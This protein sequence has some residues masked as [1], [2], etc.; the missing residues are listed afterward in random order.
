MRIKK[1][2]YVY[3]RLQVSVSVHSDHQGKDE[4]Q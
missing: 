4:H 3:T 1:E 2:Q